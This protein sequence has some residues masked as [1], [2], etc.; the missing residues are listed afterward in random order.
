[1]LVIDASAVVELLLS[2]PVGLAVARAIAD[3]NGSLHAPELIGVEVTS[4]LRRL[5]RIGDIDAAT[6][7]GAISDLAA[8]GVETYEHLPLLPRVLALRDTLTSHDACYVALA[9]GLGVRL[10]TCDA[11]LARSHGHN[12]SVD[13]VVA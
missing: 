2:T 7:E 13:L 10:I 12:A 9:E 11:K 8:L 4:V 5:I 1:L 3:D 6:A